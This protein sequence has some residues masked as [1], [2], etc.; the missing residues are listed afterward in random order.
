MRE[1]KCKAAEWED[2]GVELEFDGDVLNN[3]KADNPKDNNACLRQLFTR[4]LKHVNPEPSWKA[5]IEAV[6]KGLNDQELA[7][8]LKSKYRV[9]T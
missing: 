1:L 7:R 3:I 4:W 5:I 8:K 9:N 6:E 2:I